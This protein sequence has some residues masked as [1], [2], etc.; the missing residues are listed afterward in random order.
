[1]RVVAEK[2]GIEQSRE[3]LQ[4]LGEK[5]V[6]GGWENFCKNILS[7]VNWKEGENLIIDGI[8]HK[9]ALDNLKKITNPSNVYLIYIDLDF[10][11]RENRITNSDSAEDLKKYDS[12]STEKQVFSIL[13][14]LSD[15][16]IDGNKKIEEI[17]SEIL[18]WIN[19]K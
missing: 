4:K 8:R 7:V 19:T 12:H 1:M 11:N 3:N 2:K 14:D 16:I 9:E 5:E 17:V 15:L 6:E 18:V 13:S 10:T